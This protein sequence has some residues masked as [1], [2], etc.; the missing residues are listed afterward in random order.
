MWVCVLCNS[1]K[2]T[3]VDVSSHVDLISCAELR[4]EETFQTFTVGT[5]QSLRYEIY[6]SAALT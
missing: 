6:L 3:V 5:C 1:F 4:S 2:G